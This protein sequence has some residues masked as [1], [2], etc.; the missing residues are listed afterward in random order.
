MNN[1]NGKLN[2]VMHFFA[3]TGC[4]FY[5]MVNCAAFTNY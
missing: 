5:E 4:L 3:C 2:N 1:D